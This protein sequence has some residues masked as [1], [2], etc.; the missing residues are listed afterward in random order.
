MVAVYVDD[1]ILIAFNPEEMQEVEWALTDEFKMKDMGPLHYC[2]GVSIIQGEDCIWLHQK[3]YILNML[4]RFGLA[5]AKTVSTPA[6]LSAKLVKED[7]ISKD[8]DQVKYQSM[9]GSLLYADMATHPDIAQAVGAVSKFNA[10]PSEAHLTAAKGI[11]QYLRGT[12]DLALRY[13]KSENEL[14][15]GYSDADWGGDSDDRHSTPGNLFLMA[16][17]AVSCLSKKQAVVALSTSEVEY[18]ALSLATQEAV[19]LRKLLAELN[20][21]NK[22]VMMMEDNQGAIAIAKNPIAHSRTKYIDI[23][24]HYVREA[25]QNGV[26]NLQYCPTNEMVADLLTKPLSKGRFENLRQAMGINIIVVTES[27]N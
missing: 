23:Q 6:D 27:A 12:V 26:I 5:E 10:K 13:H 2:L 8:V 22:P 9:V 1:L 24:Y 4:K 16:G 20:L 3:Q 14:L 15:V 19:S 18:I 21:P 11:L 17:G 25:L 7:G